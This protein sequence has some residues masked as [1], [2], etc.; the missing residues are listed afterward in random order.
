MK[1]NLRE[2]TILLLCA[3]TLGACTF[4]YEWEPYQIAA[5]RVTTEE[6]L[7]RGS[8]VS[9]VSSQSNTN[10]RSLECSKSIKIDYE[11]SLSDAIVT[12]LTDELRKRKITVSGTANKSLRIIVTHACYDPR[13]FVIRAQ[14]DL[15]SR[16][17]TA[18][19]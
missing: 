8:T 17:G 2:I 3:L 4:N 1:N 12:Q 16:R 18:T 5:E 15:R 6:S 19:D 7:A 10:I 13:F 11:R 9:V 14:L